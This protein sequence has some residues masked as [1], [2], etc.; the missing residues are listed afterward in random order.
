[1]SR[2]VDLLGELVPELSR[3]IPGQHPRLKS[4]LCGPDQPDPHVDI[5]S[6]Y[7]DDRAGDGHPNLSG[8]V[9][10]TCAQSV[11]TGTRSGVPFAEQ[12]EHQTNVEGCCFGDEDEVSVWV[13]VE[14]VADLVVGFKYLRR[15]RC[16]S[17]LC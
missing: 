9:L 7:L 4:A 16:T 6:R 2:M 13:L 8:R 10:G 3:L 15:I 11:R 12:G 1:M 14:R 5:M 17:F